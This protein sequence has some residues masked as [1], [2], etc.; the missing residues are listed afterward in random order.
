MLHH[1][2][3]LMC[4]ETLVEPKDLIPARGL[5][6]TQRVPRVAVKDV[7]KGWKGGAMLP[8]EVA[9]AIARKLQMKT[10][11][12]WREW[13]KSGQRP[14]NIPASPH[15]MYRDDGWIS[16]PDWLGVTSRNARRSTM[17][18]FAAARVI[19]RRLK[20]DGVRA[21]KAWSTSGQRP[22]N[23]PASPYMMYRD[24]GWISMP[25]WLGYKARI[26]RSTMLLPFTA[27]RA[28]A[29]GLNLRSKKE[30]ETWCKA[31]HRPSNIPADPRHSYRNNG[32]IS[33]PDWLGYNNR[34]KRRKVVHE[35]PW[36]RQPLPPSTP[37]TG[38]PTTS[39][40]LLLSSTWSG[41]TPPGPSGGHAHESFGACGAGEYDW[42]TGVAVLAGREADQHDCT[43]DDHWRNVELELDLSRLPEFC[44]CPGSCT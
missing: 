19:V 41:D 18:P 3:D 24:D 2:I 14:F 30:W 13:S 21:W 32:W 42:S 10:R 36:V 7:E 16:M 40:P 6:T 25:D 44:P 9:R 26:S 23:I 38:A 15:V 20:L 34:L 39:T 27:A 4:S 35:R 28:I 17:L 22:F 33:I 43:V 37:G 1:A 11:P 8:F 5:D 31:G 12:E 29:R